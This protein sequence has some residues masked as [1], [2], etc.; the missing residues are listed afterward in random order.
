MVYNSKARVS[1]HR[2]IAGVCD[3]S[4]PP[5]RAERGR[6]VGGHERGHRPAGAGLR[7]D[8]VEP[9]QAA[10]GAQRVH[11]RE[12][13]AR[14]A[15]LHCF[16]G[17]F[18]C[19][20]WVSLTQRIPRAVVC[21]PPR[22]AGCWPSDTAAPAARSLDDSARAGDVI[23]FGKPFRLRVHPALLDRPVFLHSQLLSAVRHVR[24]PPEPASPPPIRSTPC[25]ALAATPRCPSTRKC[26]RR[27]FARSR[28]RGS[29]SSRCA[30]RALRTAAN[31]WGGT[32]R[33]A[34]LRGTGPAGGGQRVR[35]LTRAL[36]LSISARRPTRRF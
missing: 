5:L 35:S 36:A 34:P 19:S 2:A 10:R 7:G 30:W 14:G 27:P 15:F 26:A 24:A 28:V 9:L 16:V 18:V 22:Q 13:N 23:T 25:P 33:D 3:R 1:R 12:V 29:W 4:P 6:P 8:D 32:G 20:C 17:S 21:E 11:H 31:T